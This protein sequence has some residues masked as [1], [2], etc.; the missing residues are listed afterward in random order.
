MASPLT[1]DKCVQI[2]HHRQHQY[3]QCTPSEKKS[4]N[5]NTQNQIQLHHHMIIVLSQERATHK[6]P[7]K[8][9]VSK[10]WWS[11]LW[12]LCW[13]FISF[14]ETIAFVFSLIFGMALPILWFWIFPLH[15]WALIFSLTIH[16]MS[17]GRVKMDMNIM[18]SWTRLQWEL[19]AAT[20][21]NFENALWIIQS[22]IADG[23]KMRPTP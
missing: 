9:R 17:V 15:K 4:T 23:W 12:K 5:T 3:W 18:S 7:R 13:S 22:G 10:L 21:C 20:Y 8:F 11:I 19:L 6:Y 16:L 2:S 1:G 14:C